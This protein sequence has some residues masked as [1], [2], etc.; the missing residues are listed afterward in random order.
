MEQT[1]QV[2]YTTPIGELHTVEAG[3]KYIFR[4]NTSD[5]KLYEAAGGSDDYYI[6]K[7]AVAT[8]VI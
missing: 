1:F 8:I 6:T 7:T 3:A 4:R 5:N 2:D